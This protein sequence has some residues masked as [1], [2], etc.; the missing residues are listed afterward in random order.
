MFCHI[1]GVTFSLLLD[2][3][4]D[5]VVL[6]SLPG[7]VNGLLG[8]SAL[9]GVCNPA[10]KIDGPDSDIVFESISLLSVVEFSAIGVVSHASF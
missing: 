7:P 9:V 1:I 8:E 6:H 2:S 4:G 3:A 5:C 10:P